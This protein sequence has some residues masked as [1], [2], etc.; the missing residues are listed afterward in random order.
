MT[1]WGSDDGE[2]YKRDGQ[3]DNLVNIDLKAELNFELDFFTVFV[4][5][6]NIVL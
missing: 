5:V 3:R 2:S 6:R 1:C 4:L